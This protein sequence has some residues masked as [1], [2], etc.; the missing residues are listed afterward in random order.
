MCGFVGAS[1][2]EIFARLSAVV[3]TDLF[4]AV[5]W[6]LYFA[7]GLCLFAGGGDRRGGS[8][9]RFGRG[10]GADP[11]GGGGAFQPPRRR[12]SRIA[13]PLR[14]GVDPASGSGAQ[15]GGE[16]S[17]LAPTVDAGGGIRWISGVWNPRNG[18]GTLGGIA[19][20]ESSLQRCFRRRK[21]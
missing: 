2:F 12:W 5:R 7:S 18:G 21:L 3:G 19:W 15:A 6:I 20:K 14:R 1:V 11:L 10:D 4:G 9:A 16:K 13:D 8:F 17:G